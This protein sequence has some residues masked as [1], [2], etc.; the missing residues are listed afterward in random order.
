VASVDVSVLSWQLE[1]VDESCFDMWILVSKWGG[2]TWPRHGLPCGT[3][4]W[5]FV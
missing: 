1:Y 3:V 2:A 4:I 5:L